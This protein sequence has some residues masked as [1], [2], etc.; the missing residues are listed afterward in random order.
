[1]WDDE[2]DISDQKELDQN[3]RRKRNTCSRPDGSNDPSKVRPYLKWEVLQCGLKTSG[4][5]GYGE[6]RTRMDS[7]RKDIECYFDRLKQSFMVLKVPNNFR[8][9]VNIAD[10]MFTLVA[11]QNMILECK[12]ATNEY[13]SWELQENWQNVN[14]AAVPEINWIDL[15]HALDLVE[16]EDMTEEEA[17]VDHF[18]RCLPQIRKKNKNNAEIHNNDGYHDV[19]NTFFPLDYQ[20]RIMQ[21][22]AGWTEDI[23]MNLKKF[24]LHGNKSFW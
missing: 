9:K 7:V 6:W 15:E 4:E 18:I 13:H 12:V 19:G 3:R 2:D 8:K 10:M 24:S 16:E 11:I 23:Q 17:A 14:P 21:H 5:P 1:M 22:L 20:V